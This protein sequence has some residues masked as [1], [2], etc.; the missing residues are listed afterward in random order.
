MHV[1]Y[2]MQNMTA[3]IAW[4]QRSGNCGNMVYQA[5]FLAACPGVSPL[6][7]IINGRGSLEWLASFNIYWQNVTLSDIQTWWIAVATIIGWEAR[8][9]V[10]IIVC[11]QCGAIRIL[12]L[13]NEPQ[14]TTW[15]AEQQNTTQWRDLRI[16]L[17]R[18]TTGGG[19]HAEELARQW[20]KYGFP[21]EIA[22][23]LWRYER[24]Y[25][26]PADAEAGVAVT[27][28]GVAA[29]WHHSPTNL[30]EK[31]ATFF[32]VSTNMFMPSNRSPAATSPTAEASSTARDGKI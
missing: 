27:V 26:S 16:C 1:W 17:E 7:S 22:A 8:S 15:T 6:V 19:G 20:I 30:S 23:A 31:Q 9:I 11:K 3:S 29:W 18:L 14:N 28:T 25:S 24:G 4:Q 10:R 13:S 2:M 21:K 5:L 12:S 32:C